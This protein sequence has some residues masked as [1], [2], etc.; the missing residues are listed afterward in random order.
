MCFVTCLTKETLPAGGGSSTHAGQ[1]GCMQFSR[2]LLGS[3]PTFLRL[4]L[5]SGEQRSDLCCTRPATYALAGRTGQPRRPFQPASCGGDAH[6]SS[7]HDCTRRAD[8][9]RQSPGSLAAARAP[10]AAKS[11]SG[12]LRPR[13]IAAGLVQSQLQAPRRQRGRASLIGPISSAPQLPLRL[14]VARAA[15]ASRFR[16]ARTCSRP[17][18]ASALSA[19]LQRR[20]GA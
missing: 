20:V 9:R 11:T 2:E 5:R 3:G 7:E 15:K 16:G 19:S 17:R 8:K 18:R 6:P 4:R 1:K 10:R 13:R 12:G 14:T